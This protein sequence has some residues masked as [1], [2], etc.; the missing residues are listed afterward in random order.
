MPKRAKNKKF[1]SEI[2]HLG[3]EIRRLRYDAIAFGKS[4]S[5]G[6]EP[7]KAITRAGLAAALAEFQ[8]RLSETLGRLRN[9]Q[10]SIRKV[11]TPRRRDRSRAGT[12]SRLPPPPGPGPSPST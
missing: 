8:E 1:E 5:S 10:K 11:R 6:R 9:Y 7:K 4:V 12:A 2:F 3:R